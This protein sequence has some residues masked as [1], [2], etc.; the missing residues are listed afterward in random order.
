MYDYLTSLGLMLASY[1]KWLTEH[2]IW[3]LLTFAT[4]LSISIFIG[5][6]YR[7]RVPGLSVYV[8]Y[9]IATDHALYPNTLNFEVRNLRDAPL[10]LLNP[11]FRFTKILKAGQNAHGNSATGDYEIKFKLLTDK[12]EPSVD[13]SFTTMMLRH[14]EAAFAY[15]PFEDSLDEKSL[16]EK[17]SKGK[18]G[19]LSL[20]V[21]LLSEL[22]PRVISMSVPVQRIVKAPHYPPLGGSGHPKQSKESQLPR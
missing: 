2:G 6:W 15:I 7:R 13:R 9:S 22:K 1:L 4:T 17:A 20:H 8:T 19:K 18:L 12:G 10:L 3:D 5:A 14:R 16:L 11:N 21:V